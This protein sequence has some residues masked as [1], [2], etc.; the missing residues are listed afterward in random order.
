MKTDDLINLL[1][2]NLETVP[3]GKVRNTLLL[4]VA[5]G[6][7]AALCLTVLILGMPDEA[8]N[9]GSVGRRIL[10][11]LFMIGLVV[12]GTRFLIKAARPGPVRRGPL[13]AIGLLFL[14]FFSATIAAFSISNP[15][16]WSEMIFGPQW[17]ACLVC[18]PLFAVAPFASL[19]WALRKEAPTS[20]IWTGAI[21][22]LV[23]GALSAIAYIFHNPVDSI[24]FILLWFGGPILI[25]ALVGAALGPK[26][27]RW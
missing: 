14:G 20:P 10:G 2:T 25:C 11:L 13:I 24:P 1:S 26:L 9:S 15:T 8:F 6:A 21:A 16:I 7:G 4:A 17:A 12:A 5:L 3:R 23:A 22:G 18:V 19:I 27:L